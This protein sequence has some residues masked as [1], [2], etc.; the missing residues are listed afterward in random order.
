MLVVLRPF[1]NEV[2]W[3]LDL[4]SQLE[5]ANGKDCMKSSLPLCYHAYSMYYADEPPTPRQVHWKKT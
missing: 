3:Y 5:L 2:S 4:V 1:F